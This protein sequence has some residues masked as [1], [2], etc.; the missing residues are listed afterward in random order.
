M[1]GVVVDT[2]VWIDFLGGRSADTLE[3]ALAAGTAVLPPIVVAEL[4][5]GARRRAEQS[6]IADLI[7]S[8]PV[9]STPLAHWID[10]GQLRRRLAD[11]GLSVSTP[12][13]HVAQCALDSNALLLARDAVFKRIAKHSGLRVDAG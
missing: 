13:A 9:H 2:S 8:I 3:Q 11:K 10:V 5:S 1:S 12:D 4:I 7:E 6:A